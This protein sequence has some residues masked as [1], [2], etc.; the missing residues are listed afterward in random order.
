MAFSSDGALFVVPVGRAG[1]PIGPPRRYVDVIAESLSWTGDSRSLVYVTAHGLKRLDL[2]S[3]GVEDIP[4]Q[5]EWRRELPEGSFVVHAGQLFDGRTEAL[6]RDVDI[7]IEGHCIREIVPHAESQ[8]RGRV[9]DASEGTVMPGLFEMHTHQGAAYGESLG[10]LWLAYGITSVR[11]PASNP[12]E[13]RERLESIESG[14]RP[15]PREFFTGATFDG[16]RT[17]YAGA[18]ALDGG[19]QVEAELERAQI[20]KYDFIKTYVR[21]SDPVQKRVVAR[22]HELGIPVTSH[23]LYPAVAYGGDGTEHYSG[24]SRRGYSTKISRTLRSY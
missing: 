7:V 3:G 13:S 1:E 12:F 23:E 14:R 10:R 5:L 11:E 22:A 16:S 9:I 2:E 21:L 6:Q 15:G 17:Y 19:A 20:M 4:H 8:H 18:L 24:T